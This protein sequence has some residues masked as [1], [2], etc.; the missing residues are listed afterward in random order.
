MYMYLYT[1]IYRSIHANLYIE[2]KRYIDRM[3]PMQRHA[4]DVWV[5]L[6]EVLDPSWRACITKYAYVHTYIHIYLSIYMI[7]N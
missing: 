1:Y 3:P 4:E 5:G 2:R 7:Y 6:E